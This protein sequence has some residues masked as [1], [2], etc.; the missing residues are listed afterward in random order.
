MCNAG[1]L[2]Q[3]K[4]EKMTLQSFR[5]YTDV[6]A[7]LNIPICTIS[8]GE[9]TIVAEM[10]EIIEEA[11]RKFPVEVILISNFY[12]KPPLLARVM[13]SA[14]RNNIHIVCSFDGFGHV[15][16]H[17]RG[18]P[19]VSQRVCANVQ[20]V[21]D[22][23]KSLGSSSTL[24][25]HTVLSDA[26]LHQVSDILA[27]S[28]RLRWIQTVAPKNSPAQTPRPAEGVGLRASADL[29]TVIQNLI[30]TPNV[31]QMRA[32]LRGIPAYARGSHE[33]L[34]PYL[35]SALRYVK[36]FLEP[37]GDVSLCDRT[38]IGNLNQESIQEILAA[39]G[40]TRFLERAQACE[41]C[42]LSCFTEPALFV[43][44]R[45]IVD[46]LVH[47]GTGLRL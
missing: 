32:F 44:P 17:L 42:W 38:P 5:Q 1:I 20:L 23:K 19:E 22:L 10:P 2:A 21:T 4:T 24:E 9:P 46:A 15:A 27:L 12:T 11:A 30:T 33:K 26:N 6:L 34:C 14:L 13:E 28:R 43:N 16:D 18:A 47:R 31:R 25:M 37:N 40:Y 3:P 35:N 8:G 45:N 39:D 7:D 41:G 29:D 36:I